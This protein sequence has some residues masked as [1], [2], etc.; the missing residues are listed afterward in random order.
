MIRK[1]VDR[2]G[3]EAQLDITIEECAELIHDI[4]IYKRSITKH[5]Y[6]T[7]IVA[8][9]AHAQLVEGVAQAMNA[10]NSLVYALGIAKNELDK[11]IKESDCK[12]FMKA[13]GRLPKKEELDDSHFRKGN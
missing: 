6:S 13:F 1:I 4:S 2:Y 10:I 12:S 11:E 8:K 9:V 3:K 7:Y 5:G